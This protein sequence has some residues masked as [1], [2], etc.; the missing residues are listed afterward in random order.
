[1]RGLGR[2]PQSNGPRYSTGVPYDRNAPVTAV[3]QP[4]TRPLAQ[5]PLDLPVSL[6]DP[7]ADDPA[8]MLLELKLPHDD[9]PPRHLAGFAFF[10]LR[11]VRAFLPQF[12][13]ARCLVGPYE[14]AMSST[15][16]L[17]SRVVLDHREPF[18]YLCGV[19]TPRTWSHNLHLPMIYAPGERIEAET[20]DGVR[21]TVNHAREVAIP[22]VEDG[23]QGFPLSYTTCR[24]WQFGLA[25]VGYNG[26]R[27][28]WR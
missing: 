22:W 14:L 19:A 21:I 3:R 13:C 7:R 26:E 10:W 25:H 20:Y 28:V 18:A 23:W 27:P 8:A 1:M 2:V 11:Y 6:I 16:A 15:M 12:H 9:D 4:R 17:P 24:N 5:L